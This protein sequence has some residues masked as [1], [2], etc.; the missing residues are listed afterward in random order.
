MQIILNNA[1]TPK[2]DLFI[3]SPYQWQFRRKLGCIRI[4][5]TL[6]CFRVFLFWQTFLKIC[7]MLNIVI[8]SHIQ[9]SFLTI[10][11][12]WGKT[13]DILQKLGD[14]G[15]V[16]T[17]EYLFCF[18]DIYFLRTVSENMQLTWY[19]DLKPYT[20]DFK[21]LSQNW[22]YNWNGSDEDIIY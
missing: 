8:E 18:K 21:S 5:I 22:P 19:Y 13:D 20:W 11:N 17:I 10:L 7:N 9:R 16:V 4:L 15:S 12:H 3:M 2:C 6:L 1:M 14:F